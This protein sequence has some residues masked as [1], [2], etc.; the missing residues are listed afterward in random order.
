MPSDIGSQLKHTHPEFSHKHPTTP[1]ARVKDHPAL[2][3]E[4]LDS[5]NVL[6]PPKDSNKKGDVG[7]DIYL[8]ADEDITKDPAWLNGV[9]PNAAGKTENAVSCCIIVND[10]GTGYVDAFYMYFYAYNQGQVIFG[11]E[12][13]DHL[14]DW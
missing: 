4:N 14:G 11:K 7:N 9:L 6:D 12:L 13:G 1:G 10:H 5:L 2:T 3:L 8:S